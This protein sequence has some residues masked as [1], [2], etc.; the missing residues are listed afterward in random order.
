MSHVTYFKQPK[1]KY[2]N[3]R[4]TYNNYNYDSKLEANFAASLDTLKRAGKIADWQKQKTIKLYAYDRF[5]CAYRIDF[6]VEHLDGTLE[7]L[8]VKGYPTQVWKFKWKLFE[9]QL[10]ETEPQN[11]ATV[12]YG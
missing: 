2:F 1:N 7:Y 3:V 11:K 9:A 6:V 4:Q 12:V 5:I 8:E 10:A